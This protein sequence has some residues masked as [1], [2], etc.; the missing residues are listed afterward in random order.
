MSKTTIRVVSL[1]KTSLVD[2][3][4]SARRLAQ[5]YLQACKSLIEEAKLTMVMVWLAAEPVEPNP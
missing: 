1:K 3:G 2:F 4:D 5:G